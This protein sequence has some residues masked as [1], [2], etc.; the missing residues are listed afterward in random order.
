MLQL[1]QPTKS[2]DRV[3]SCSW[4]WGDVRI[5]SLMSELWHLHH[6]TGGSTLSCIEWERTSSGH[7]YGLE[8]F[9]VV[10]ML[11]LSKD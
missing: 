7:G 9:L 11:A 10:G 4:G 8:E 1:L 6:Q 5:M 3:W 2:P